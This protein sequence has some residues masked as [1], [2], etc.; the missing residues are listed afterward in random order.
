MAEPL[1][2]LLHPGVPERL[3]QRLQAQWPAF[4]ATRFVQDALLNYEP[5]ALMA[6]GQRL[7]DGLARHL[8]PQVPEALALLTAALEPP[9]PLDARGEPVSDGRPDSVFIYLPFSLYIAQQA[10]DHPEAA[11]D[12]MHALTQ[13]FTAEF[14]IR[15]FLERHPGPSWARLQHWQHDPSA[16][17]R[18]LVSEG[19]RPRLPWAARLK[20][21]Q[22]DPRPVLPLLVALRDDVS[23]YVRRSVANH[24]GDIAKDHPDLAVATAQAWRDPAQPVR[25]QL[26]R[27]ALRVPLKQGH[28]GALA[29]FGL[30]HASALEVTQASLWPE[31][32]R[33]GQALEVSL[34]L[35]NPSA[36]A[37][38][39]LV[40]LVVHYRK[41][42]GQA[43][44]KVF[45]LSTVDLAPGAHQVLSKRL[46]LAQ[47]TT[48]THHPGEHAVAVQINGQA[49][50]L[51]RFEL[52][53]AA[54]AAAPS[55]PFTPFAPPNKP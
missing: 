34:T 24:L 44:P 30:G 54:D 31:R 20:T 14:C 46:S 22:A 11:L 45:K 7:A 29:V 6:R 4:E 53:A 35:H 13:R 48:R 40:D 55:S 17:V 10:L 18:R 43:R 23:S 52:L 1:K 25:D 51:G 28:P 12:A 27:H 8:P 49:Q 26:L 15:P 19:T 16:H 2:H 36:Q 41:A 37:Q 50:P 32:P 21:L 39:A 38:T 9:L 42:D 5:L 33:I 47:M 3:A